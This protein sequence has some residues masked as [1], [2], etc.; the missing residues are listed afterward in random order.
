[1]KVQSSKAQKGKGQ[2]WYDHLQKSPLTPPAKVFQIVW[3]V[4]YILMAVSFLVYLIEHGG[5]D[6]TG[7]VLFLIQLVLN[8]IWPYLFFKRRAIQT[9]FYVLIALWILL[10]TTIAWFYH[11]ESPISATLLLP[12][13]LWIS[14]ALYLNGYIFVY[15]N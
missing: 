3:P 6:P 2:K 14:F 15:N 8:V 7:I 5:D 11:V 10:L 1:M 9:A 13:Y 12:Y 4:L